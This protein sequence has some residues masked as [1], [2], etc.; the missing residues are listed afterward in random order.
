MLA[1]LLK[2]EWLKVR[3]YRAFWIILIFLF[4]LLPVI[5]VAVA[6]IYKRSSETL[7]QGGPA[8]DTNVVD[9]VLGYPFN[10]NT[11]FY[12][13]AYINNGL[14][15][16]WGVLL[17]MMIGNEFQ[18]RTLRQNVI[19][20]QERNHIIHSKL[21]L[22]GIFSF[23]SAVLVVISGFITGT[24]YSNV[25][26]QMNIDILKNLG[27]SFFAAIIQMLFALVFAF[28]IKRPAISVILYLIYTIFI[29][30][31]L[32]GILAGLARFKYAKLLFTQAADELTINPFT[33]N[34]VKET[35]MLLD[36]SAVWIACVLYAAVILFALY[37]YI[38]RTVLK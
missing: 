5:S 22:V 25:P 18:N 27:I 19:D 23:I 34:I 9:M 13:I 36:P 31:V 12:T 26:L 1:T 30:N 17:I 2:I 3:K 6:E 8:G 10:F 35:E 24:L 4:I 15:I 32:V 33:K 20:G 7:S 28:M 16:A 11:V 38:N 29:E 14:N 21:I 37:Q